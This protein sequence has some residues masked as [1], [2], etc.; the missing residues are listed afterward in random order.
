MFELVVSVAGAVWMGWVYREARRRGQRPPLDG[1]RVAGGVAWSVV[2]HQVD[3]H[4]LAGVQQSRLRGMVWSSLSSSVL[5]AVSD[6]EVGV[7]T[8]LG[9][10]VGTILHRLW[11]GL[12]TPLPT[13]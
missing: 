13:E 7:D 11:Y 1:R 3:D 8:V 2:Y 12:L 5:S 9:V 6:S 10:F 4:D